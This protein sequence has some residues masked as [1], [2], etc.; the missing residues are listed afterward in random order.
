L[1]GALPEHAS[2][3]VQQQIVHV[4]GADVCQQLRRFET[5]AKE[6]G[7]NITVRRVRALAGRRMGN[8]KPNGAKT[9]NCR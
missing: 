7:Q 2:R 5:K 1:A 9:I 6:D 4:K 3:R 8:K